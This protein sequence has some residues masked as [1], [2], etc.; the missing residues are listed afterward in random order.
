MTEKEIIAKIKSRGYWKVQ[1]R[2]TVF[3][4]TLMPDRNALRDIVQKN[5]VE[6]RGWDYPHISH[7]SNPQQRRPTVG[8]DFVEG[9]VD[10][11][12]FVEFW[13]MYQSGQ[14]IHLFGV[15]EDWFDRNQWPVS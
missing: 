4:K 1:F 10:W 8:D 12:E 15:H 3:N 7:W 11:S 2:P 5:S 13:R 6:I 14:F 9:G